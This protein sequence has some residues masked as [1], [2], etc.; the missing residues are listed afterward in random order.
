M[1]SG[2]MKRVDA[3]QL[4]ALVRVSLLSEW[5]QQQQKGGKKFKIPILIRSLIFYLIMGFSLGISLINRAPPL[6][7]ALFCYAYFMIMTGFAVIMEGSQILL[8][9]EDLD[10]LMHRPLSSSTF[11]LARLLHMMIFIIIFSTG[12]CFGPAVVVFFYPETP[13]LFPL[14]FWGVA[15]FAV[16][17]TA[18]GMILLYTWMLRVFRFE[19]LKSFIYIIQ[20]VFTLILILVY[21]FIARSGWESSATRFQI[22]QSWIQWLP[23]GWFT[24]IISSIIQPGN[25]PS[26]F[27]FI[28]IGATL[29][30]M[31]IGFQRLSVNYME[32][33][34]LLSLHAPEQK[35]HSASAFPTKSIWTRLFPDSESRAGFFLALQILRRDKLVKM[36]ILPTIAIPLVLLLWGFIEGDIQDP[37]I[38]PVTGQG[39]TPIQMLPFFI[40]FMFYMI[41]RGALYSQDWEAAWIFQSAPIAS[42]KRFIQ[43]VQRGLITGAIIPFYLILLMILCFRFNPVHAL[44]H[45]LFLYCLGMVFL[46]IL[47]LRENEFPFSKKRER[48]ERIGGFSFMLWLIPFQIITYLLQMIAYTSQR[49][50]WIALAGL[51]VFREVLILTVVHRVGKQPSR[52]IP[53]STPGNHGREIFKGKNNLHNR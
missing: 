31:V 52:G 43:G 40:A 16:L 44:Q 26:F 8:V 12:L 5:R 24:L 38:I 23:P 19:K 33:V 50:W 13:Q 27:V 53:N 30:V 2:L 48:G 47:N 36:T 28:V 11:F 1:N 37:F 42:P 21:Q 34:S 46:A 6:L 3:D 32:D 29:A 45:T 41:M 51:I 7:Y 35:R 9:P 22:D 10:V 14:V 49:N 18:A 25:H 4:K 20:F 17:F 39:S 15:Y